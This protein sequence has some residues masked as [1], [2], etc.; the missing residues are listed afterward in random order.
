MYNTA[1]I[2]VT[3][4]KR[5]ADWLFRI[6]R[7]YKKNQTTSCFDVRHCCFK[8]TRSLN[9]VTFRLGAAKTSLTRVS[10]LQHFML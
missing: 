1:T 8:A 5:T 9:I 3:N 2:N 6:I 7:I 4:S 10:V